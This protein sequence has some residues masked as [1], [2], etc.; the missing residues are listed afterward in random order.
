MLVR[1]VFMRRYGVFLIIGFVLLSFLPSRATS[2]KPSFAFPALPTSHLFQCY[3][4]EF[5][6]IDAVNE[7]NNMFYYASRRQPKSSAEIWNNYSDMPSIAVL[8]GSDKFISTGKDTEIWPMENDSFLHVKRNE[9]QNKYEIVLSKYKGGE[10][11]WSRNLSKIVGTKENITIFNLSDKLVYFYVGNKTFFFSIETGLLLKFYEGNLNFIR[12]RNDVAIL[13]GSKY[14]F[15]D[16]C[17]LSVMWELPNYRFAR[18]SNDR[19]LFCKKMDNTSEK[20]PFKYSLHDLWTGKLLKEF[21]LGDLEFMPGYAPQIPPDNAA[22]VGD[23]FVSACV[24]PRFGGNAFIFG[25]DITNIKLLF[26]K[27]VE[28][29][30]Y[31]AIRCDDDYIYYR[32]NAGITC[33]DPKNGNIVWRVPT[34]FILGSIKIAS[35]RLTLNRAFFDEDGSVKEGLFENKEG[36]WELLGKASYN[37]SIGFSFGIHLIKQGILH[38]PYNRKEPIELIELKTGKKIF[39]LKLPTWEGR[40]SNPVFTIQDNV[41]YVSCDQMGLYEI[42]LTTGEYDY[43]QLK[44]QTPEKDSCLSNRIA[45]NDRYVCA[46]IWK[47]K[48]AAFDRKTKSLKIIYEGWI[49]DYYTFPVVRGDFLYCVGIKDVQR[50]SI[51]DGS[52]KKMP[53][54]VFDVSGNIIF[55]NGDVVDLEG[56]LILGAYGKNKFD[57]MTKF[58]VDDCQIVD[59]MAVALNSGKTVQR[60]GTKGGYMQYLCDGKSLY[61]WD[62]KGFVKYDPCPTFLIENLGTANGKMRFKIAM[63]RDDGL[64]QPLSG[65]IYFAPMQNKDIIKLENVDFELSGLRFGEEKYFEFDIPDGTQSDETFV[66]TVESNG[67]L[68]TEKSNLDKTFYKKQIAFE[69]IPISYSQQL[70]VVTTLWKY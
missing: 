34:L 42:N 69:G 28:C 8:N 51:L 60:F 37:E 7:L 15:Y 64:S 36:T 55:S 49:Q 9:T 52:I 66:L 63:T 67:L 16:L 29:A 46:I 65:K 41:L 47:D 53:D 38:I 22:C 62:M 14:Y 20:N 17:T 58:C 70:S 21:T 54:C 56:N 50:I 6:K 11:E 13:V 61:R 31:L 24:K 18:C 2:E 10:I 12:F 1:E 5:L 23:I 43:F 35:D 33:L 40:I 45:S 4:G 3:Q 39:T 25:Y 30:M 32:N 27:D 26:I 19:I 48:W 59:D 68:D 44:T 57:Y